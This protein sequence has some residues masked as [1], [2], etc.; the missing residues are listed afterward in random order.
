[1][2]DA[3]AAGDEAAY[4]ARI[5][6][7]TGRLPPPPPQAPPPPPPGPPPNWYPDPSGR[8]RLRYWDGYSWTG[9]TA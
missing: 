8:F 1:D 6:Q 2:P 3:G 4:V 7:L 9:H 5:G